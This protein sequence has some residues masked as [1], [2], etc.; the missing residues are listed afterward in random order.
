MPS[1]T[2]HIDHIVPVSKGGASEMDNLQTLCFDCN[3]GK[4]NQDD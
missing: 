4:K 3:E 1:V 2:L